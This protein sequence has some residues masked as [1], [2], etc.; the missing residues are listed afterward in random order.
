MQISAKANLH[1]SDQIA[2]IWRLQIRPKV[3][4]TA[5]PRVCD[6]GGEDLGAVDLLSLPGALPQH[7]NRVWGGVFWW[8]V[9]RQCWLPEQSEEVGVRAGKLN[10]V[11]ISQHHLMSSQW[12]YSILICC[13]VPRWVSNL[14]SYQKPIF[15]SQT[16]PLT[17]TKSYLWQDYIE[18]TLF[19]AA[20]ACNQVYLPF[21]MLHFRLANAQTLH[22]MA[23]IDVFKCLTFLGWGIGQL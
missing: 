8:R 18:L 13:I 22:H 2:I 12:N 7:V 15:A 10:L 4:G 16:V 23:N 14:P 1:F 21:V 11:D 6:H 17:F 3:E 19:C 20:A 9:A 5:N